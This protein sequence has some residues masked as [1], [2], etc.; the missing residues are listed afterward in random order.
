[1]SPIAILTHPGD[2]DVGGAR[3]DRAGYGFINLK[4]GVQLPRP[5]PSH[6]T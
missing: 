3:R 5:L 6:A 2:L 1:M 4:G